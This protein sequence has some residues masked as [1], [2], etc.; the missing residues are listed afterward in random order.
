MKL[1]MQQTEVIL[2]VDTH[3]DVHVGAVINHSGKLLGTKTVSANLAGYLDLLS[4]VSSFGIV[5]TRSIRA[6]VIPARKVDF[7]RTVSIL[8]TLLSRLNI[9]PAQPLVFSLFGRPAR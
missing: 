2:G 3:L 4:W 6:M 7:M 8:F 1:E 5:A 9:R